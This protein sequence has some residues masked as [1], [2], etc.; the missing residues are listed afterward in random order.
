MIQ[1]IKYNDDCPPILK[2]QG[3]KQTEK[4]VSSFKRASKNLIN[5]YVTGDRKFPNLKYYS[6]PIVKSALMKSHHSKCC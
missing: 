4:D 3:K 5:K 2:N 1:V 6:S